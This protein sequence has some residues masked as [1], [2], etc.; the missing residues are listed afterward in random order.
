M[1]SIVVSHYG[2]GDFKDVQSAIDSIPKNNKE[3]VTIY[4]REGRYRQRIIVDSPNITL[5]GIGKVTI[6]YD[7]GANDIGEDGKPIGTFRTATTMIAAKNF[8]AIN[9]SFENA[10]GPGAV[11][12]QALALFINADRVCF[13]R[14]KFLGSQ[15]TI[16]TGN[17]NEAE[18]DGAGEGI[19]HRMY[20]KDC[21]IEGDVDYIFGGGTAV[22]ENCEIY[23]LDR[24]V[25]EGH[26]NGFIT[27]ASTNESTRFG[28]VFLGCKLTGVGKKETVY[29][30]RPW[31]DF[32][33]VAFLYCHMEEQMKR[34]G[35]HNW[36]QSEREKTTRYLE[37]GTTGL[38]SNLNERVAWSKQLNAQEVLE[39]TVE[40]ILSG[41]DD[42]QPCFR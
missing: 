10:A 27:A 38:R 2:K 24:H 20:F 22:F 42:W 18:H 39:Y 23:T 15:D 41:A 16:Y 30:G 35:W 37:Y 7:V 11:A 14:C 6:T 9:V 36:S 1:K 19:E 34:E 40:K 32:A 21:Y 29:L 31:R 12:G 26:T 8:T 5:V 17:S 25:E 3:N 13:H 4:I 28:Y 33:N